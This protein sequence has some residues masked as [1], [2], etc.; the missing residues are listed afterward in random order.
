M[1][2]LL[3]FLLL[4]PAPP[5]DGICVWGGSLCPQ[6]SR[7]TW[8]GRVRFTQGLWIHPVSTWGLAALAPCQDSPFSLIHLPC[9]WSQRVRAPL[10][11]YPNSGPLQVHGPTQYIHISSW[12][13]VGN[14]ET[15]RPHAE[16]G[17]SA[18]SGTSF[19]LR[20]YPVP[21]ASVGP[22]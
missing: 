7:K 16:H 20:C 15:H 6:G 5:W 3:G 1:L 2:S 18:Y 4:L 17:R 11:P 21:P 8:W 19:K 22:F 12:R 9:L 13:I 10:H 14:S